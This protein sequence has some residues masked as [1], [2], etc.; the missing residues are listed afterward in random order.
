MSQSDFT[1]RMTI[2]FVLI[3]TPLWIPM[4]V[5]GVGWVTDTLRERRMAATAAQ[6]SAHVPLSAALAE[7]VAA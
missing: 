6:T 5:S 1:L 2:L 4:L 3:Y 7:S